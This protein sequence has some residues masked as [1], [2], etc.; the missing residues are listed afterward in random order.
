MLDLRQKKILGV[1]ILLCL[2]FIAYEVFA[3]NNPTITIITFLIF[4]LLFLASLKLKVSN[5]V[6]SAWGFP[7]W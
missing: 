1:I 5:S 2:N 4:I 6:Y 7:L 3:P